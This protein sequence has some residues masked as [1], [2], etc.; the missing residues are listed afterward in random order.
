M[1]EDKQYKWEEFAVKEPCFDHGQTNYECSRFHTV[2]HVAHIEYA[3]R[4]LKDGEIR[5]NLVYD[6]SRLKDKRIS[7]SW[8]SPKDWSKMKGFRY[9]HIRFTFDWTSIIA[10]KRFYKIEISDYK[11]PAPRV[12]VTDR[13]HE[14][15]DS[16]NH[17]SMKGPWF[18]DHDRGTHF[19]HESDCCVEFLIEDSISLD[20]CSKIDFV[21]HHPWWC[22][23]HRNDPDRCKDK[24]HTADKA[25]SLFL[26]SAISQSLDLSRFGFSLE[27]KGKRRPSIELHKAMSLIWMQLMSEKIKFKG[28]AGSESVKSKALA[29]AILHAY[30]LQKIEEV[31]S[32]AAYFRSSEELIESCARLVCAHTG[33][34]D[35][36]MLIS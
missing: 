21:D 8:V 3:L 23:L 25:A 26:S 27:I 31:Y 36:R 10:G 24:K 33:V 17:R 18:Y 4:I 20:H 30:S 5:P 16:Y 15:F 9:G 19:F 1:S 28:K 6:K 29:R 32:L 34:E 7:V 11:I 14:C 2:S 13:K 35:H 12:L 22:S